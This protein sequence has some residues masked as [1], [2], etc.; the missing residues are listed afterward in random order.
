[1]NAEI[2]ASGSEM[3]TPARI[4]TNSLYLTERLNT[5]GIEVVGKEI[6]G[7]DRERMAHMIE[8]ALGR[9]DLLVITGGLG[10][11]EDDVTRDAVAMILGFGMH[12]DEAV[13]AVIE[14]RFARMRRKMSEINR[15][16]AFILDTAEI[17]P[18]DRGTAPGQWIEAQGKIV[19]LLPGPPNEMKA[20]FEKQVFERL[21]Q[22]VPPL[23]IRTV[24]LR[25]AGMPE[26][27]LDQLISPVYK[28]YANPVTTVLAAPGDIQIHFR[29]HAE[30]EAEAEALLKEV[31]DQVAPLLGDRL[32]TR[33]GET[34]EK[35]VGDMLRARKA[36]VAVAE[37]CTG[38]GLGERIT[39]VDGSSDYFVGGFLTYTNRMKTELLDVSAQLLEQHGAVSEQAAL[40]MARGA[41][42]HT[43]ATYA[44]SVTGVAGPAG[45]TAET[46]VG[47]VYIG[48]ASERGESAR[49]FQ[50][51][52][53]RGR[54]RGFAVHYALDMLRHALIAA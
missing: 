9:A 23:V 31:V 13:Y 27:E 14:A 5:L 7:D 3:L 40:A 17:L 50:F 51:L 39:T 12:F 11:T 18:N 32:Y 46:P 45:G 28:K 44:L 6:V 43:G 20:M 42:E 24:E 30:T 21:R 4:D 36:T 22:R 38:G 53:D 1:M 33:R 47:T 26:S 35:V 16:Q 41:R 54:I 49:R 52:G 25:V 15:R 29:A 8:A 34:L 48:L 10:P 37:S 2:I 19:A